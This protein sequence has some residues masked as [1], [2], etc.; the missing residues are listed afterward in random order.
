MV[1]SGIITIAQRVVL[2]LDLP[3]A[4]SFVAEYYAS[5][6]FAWIVYNTMI[7]GLIV[8]AL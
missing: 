6:Y 3:Y 2:I 5:G 7:S 8:S 1:L 4:Q